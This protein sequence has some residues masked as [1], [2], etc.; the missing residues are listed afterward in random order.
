M[1]PLRGTFK[2]LPGI[3]EASEE[4]LWQQ[5][6]H[7]WAQVADRTSS[8]LEL[9][10][11]QVFTLEE[12][13]RDSERAFLN[14]DVNYFAARLP[15]PDW[16]RIAAAFP[17]RCLFLDIETTGLSSFYD[18]VTLVGWSYR[19]QYRAMVDPSSMTDL[20]TALE[21]EPLL[22]TFN[23]SR[24]DLPF[25]TAHFGTD[26]SHCPHLD[27][28]YPARRV[29]LKGGQKRI[30]QTLG[31]QRPGLTTGIDGAKAVELWFDYKEGD[32]Q[33]LER[34]IRYNHA[35]IEGM[36]EIL[37]HVIARSIHSS[38]SGHQH[39]ARSEVQIT[40]DRRSTRKIIVSP[41]S[42]AVGPRVVFEHLHANAKLVS[43]PIVGID[44]TGSEARKTGW[45]C[46]EG[47]SVSCSLISTDEELLQRTV[48]AK[49]FL[50]S[51]DSPLSLPK[52]RTS[53]FDDDPARNQYG[54]TRYAERLLRRRGINVYPA[55]IPS[56]Q[57]LTERGSR[58]A[59]RLRQLGVPV[60]ES[61]PGAAQ[62]ILGIPRK[63]TSLHHLKRGLERFGYD[64]DLHS[65]SHDELDAVTSALVAQFLVGGHFELLGTAEEDFLVVPTIDPNS[66]FMDTH[67]VVALSGRPAVGKTAVGKELLKHGFV[68]C[69][70]S[71]VLAD[72]LGGAPT[73]DELAKFGAEV[74]ERRGGQRWLQNSLAERVAGAERIVIDGLRHPEDH[75]FLSETWPGKC[76]HVHLCAERE[77]RAQRYM[78]REKC[79]RESFDAAEQHGIE[80]NAAVLHELAGKVIENNSLLRKACNQIL[81]ELEK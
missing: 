44:L 37:E 1:K 5:G 32:L 34:L 66:R 59:T 28:V 61:Y 56:M 13:V 18:V 27:L 21:C 33:A 51:I 42:G 73:R 22:V 77:L 12:G 75:A 64:L 31:L 29:G 46:V 72:A 16:I 6:V 20:V 45:A 43:A 25:L 7:D 50:V 8:Q 74:F 19:G 71:E 9:F 47:R 63:G 23:G 35:D 57:K 78:S 55:L 38:G 30:E 41:F 81:S 76:L 24:F 36:K 26:F 65:L 79:S 2:H 11:G 68:Y 14:G 48:D 60:V 53:A 52:G 69:R 54:I 67:A 39:F 3:S 4:R 70:F 58:L 10:E 15:R 49:P 80:R 62:D 40:R 17:E